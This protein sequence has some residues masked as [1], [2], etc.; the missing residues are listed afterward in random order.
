MPARPIH[1]ILP[2]I[3]V[4]VLATSCE[5]FGGKEDTSDQVD[6][7]NEVVSN[8]G[9]DQSVSL[10]ALVALNAS[11]STI[12]PNVNTFYTWAFESL[13]TDSALTAG[14]FTD[15][16]TV[17]A[18]QTSFT[19]DVVGTYV[20]SLNV[21]SG[22]LSSTPDMVVIDV[23]TGNTPPVADCGADVTVQV[24]TAATLD[25]SASYDPDGVSLIWSW[26]I[27]NQPA[28]SAL[29]ASSIYNS[30]GPTPTII[31]DVAGIYVVSLAVSD[32][33]LWSDPDYC[34]VTATTDNLPPIA[35]AGE[36]GM[37]P[38]CADFELKLDG[39]AS[40]DPEGTTIAYLWSLASNP[41]GS[42]TS[43]ASFDDPTLANPTFT[44]DVAGDYTFQL[45]VYDGVLWSAPDIVTYTTGDR[46]DNHGPVANAGD[47][48]TIDAEAECTGSSYTA[49]TCEDCAGETLELDGSTSY[50]PDG[51]DLNFYWSEPTAAVTIITPYSPYTQ[52]TTPPIAATFGST[53]TTQ[54][55]LYLDVSDCAS[56]AND[57]LLITHNCTGKR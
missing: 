18:V 5:I 45:S 36:G 33:V 40:Y 14:D 16:D 4:S 38:P 39:Y 3:A 23:T 21:T 50:D 57:S 53:T 20:V 17:T 12:C 32:G 2:L 42:A 7:C 24:G 25:G 30:G 6:V 13:P 9:P 51:D 52:V 46:E 10:G 1:R 56:S 8:A 11:A 31:P 54:W 29:D 19:P 26:S 28:G 27:S 47:D 35:N 43:D 34:T 22:D 41:P 44:W 49:L 48:Q 15:N 55:T 37:L